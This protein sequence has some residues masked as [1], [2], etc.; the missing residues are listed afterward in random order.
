MTDWSYLQF[1]SPI[2]ALRFLGLFGLSLL[3]LQALLALWRD[4]FLWRSSV[5]GKTSL[6]LVGA[7]AIAFTAIGSPQIAR[8]FRCLTEM[9][10][11]ANCAGGWLF[12][13]VFVACYLA[14]ELVSVIVPAIVRKVNVVT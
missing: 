14:F 9:H 10:R 3:P 1:A 7:A 13:A 8:A 2:Y 5:L 6:I 4:A 11:G 12:L